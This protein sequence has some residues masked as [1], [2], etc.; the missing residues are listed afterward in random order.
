MTTA[1]PETAIWLALKMRI[2]TLSLNYAVAWPGMTYKP[3]STPFIRVA[4]V[5]ASP[6]RQSIEN[7]QPH[8]RTGILVLSVVYPLGQD[9][10]VY[11]Q[12]AATI[13]E[14]FRDGTQMRY[15]NVCVTITKYPHVQ[16]SY[17]DN[18]FLVTPVAVPW[19]CSV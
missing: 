13:A 17:L 19:R 12:L 11:T 10:S 7:G 18:G 15:N 9:T 14:H 2:K 16:D 6:V 5:R 3:G 1:L 4:Q 8:A